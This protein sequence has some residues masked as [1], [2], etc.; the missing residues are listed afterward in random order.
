MEVGGILDHMFRLPENFAVPNVLYVEELMDNHSELPAQGLAIL[1]VNDEY[2]LEAYRLGG[3]YRKPSHHDLLALALSKQE[4]C[5]LITGDARLR[6]AAEAEG[7]IVYGTL[8]IIERLFEEALL[9]FDS[10][11]NAYAAMQEEER[12]LPW[13]QVKAQ[14]KRLHRS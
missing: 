11:N 10:I 8:W 5:P 14:L 4:E 6:E 3:I 12:R 1:E 7:T 13:G 2:M 9:N